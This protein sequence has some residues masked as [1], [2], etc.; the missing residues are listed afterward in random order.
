MLPQ[1]LGRKRHH[2]RRARASGTRPFQPVTGLVWRG[3]AFG[4]ARG[5]TGVPRIVDRYMDGKIGIGDPITHTMPLDR[6]NGAPGLM[7]EGKPI[8]SVIT[9]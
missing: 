1:G 6:I 9:F 8:R 5:R 4:G 7:H 2:R 3:T